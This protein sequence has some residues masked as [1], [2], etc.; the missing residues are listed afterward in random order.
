MRTRFESAF[1]T[2][3]R[4]VSP[5]GVELFRKPFRDLHSWPAAW[6][7]L[8]NSS[9]TSARHHRRRVCTT[10]TTQHFAA[11]LTHRSSPPSTK[12]PFFFSLV[13]LD[14]TYVHDR[15][16][17]RGLSRCG[18]SAW[19]CVSDSLQSIALRESEYLLETL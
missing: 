6:G 19:T 10:Y 9:V 17:F 1:L 11:R 18:R 3:P 4:P 16:L 5:A 8:S 7:M 2:V 14:Y 12:L 13:L 15:I